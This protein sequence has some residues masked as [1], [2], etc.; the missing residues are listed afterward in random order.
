MG[1]MGQRLL[2]QLVWAGSQSTGLLAL[3]RPLPALAITR[4]DSLSLHVYLRGRA[5]AR[6]QPSNPALYPL[7]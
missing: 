3:P 6:A 5:G 1:L 2:A 4:M 7:H